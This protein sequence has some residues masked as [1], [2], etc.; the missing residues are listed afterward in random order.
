VET[1]SNSGAADTGLDK[2]FGTAGFESPAQIDRRSQQALRAAITAI[3]TAPRLR[4]RCVRPNGLCRVAPACAR[5]GSRVSR[6]YPVYLFAA[7]HDVSQQT[8]Q[9]L[10]DAAAKLNAPIR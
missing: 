5:T 8:V 7:P 4:P 2:R 1:G 10:V 6:G 3:S 9:G